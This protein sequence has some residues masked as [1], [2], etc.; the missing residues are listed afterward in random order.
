MDEIML[1]MKAQREAEEKG[2]Q[3]FVCPIC[4]GA[5][6]FGR[7]PYNE[8]LHTGCDGCGIMIME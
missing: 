2:Q 6:H 7:S 3:E 4:G 8:H 1:F 5:A